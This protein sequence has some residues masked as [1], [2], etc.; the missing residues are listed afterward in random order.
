MVAQACDPST[1]PEVE[2]GGQELHREFGGQPGM[3]EI[4]PEKGGEERERRQEE[5][6]GRK[7]IPQ[8]L[9][10]FQVSITRDLC[11]QFMWLPIFPSRSHYCRHVE[12]PLYPKLVGKAENA[13]KNQDSENT[14][15]SS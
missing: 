15:C 8:R 9:A 14:A 5:R 6:G 10:S 7:T 1:T 3:L 2:A 13:W 11:S 12:A 4:L